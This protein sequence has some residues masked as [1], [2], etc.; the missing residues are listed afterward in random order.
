[1][2]ISIHL[3]KD[4]LL[5]LCFILIM[6][7]IKIY[8]IIFVKNKYF[9]NIIS[10][11]PFRKFIQIFL[12]IFFFIEKNRSKNRNEIK[13][14][15]Y[16][17]S[18]I[19]MIITLSFNI[20]YYYTKNNIQKKFNEIIYNIG[21][22]TKIISLYF[23]ERIILKNQFYSH[24]ILSIIIIVIILII[25]IY[26]YYIPFF[27]IIFSFYLLLE[28]YSQSFYL[29]LITYMDNFLYINIF[30]LGSIIGIIDLL[31]L[32]FIEQKKDNFLKEIDKIW[33]LF[34]FYIFYNYIY[35]LIL[36]K[37]G[38]IH[39]RICELT[40]YLIIFS[41]NTQLDLTFLIKSIF[42]FLLIISILIYLEIIELRFCS[43]N[44]NIKYQIELREKEHMKLIEKDENEITQFNE[45]T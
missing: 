36:R 22:L 13:F 14:M 18:I 8:D 41:I 11:K 25:Y 43:L 16:K 26:F 20:I 12:I 3:N 33:Y 23:I 9:G 34:P 28:S 29:T 2:F 38:P 4:H 39:I 17:N 15:L 10:N 19:F 7:L 5:Y 44:K 35:F 6:L 42:I 40:V 37:L 24:H 27:N 21:I 1:M 45:I 30:L 31:Y 32:L